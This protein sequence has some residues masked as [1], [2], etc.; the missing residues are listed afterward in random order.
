MY[1]SSSLLPTDNTMPQLST[2]WDASVMLDIFNQHLIDKSTLN[3]CEIVSAT[4]QRIRYRA[5]QRS[6]NLYELKLRHRHSRRTQKRWVTST[7]YKNQRAKKKFKQLANQT[8]GFK[9][10]AI[11][12][13]MPI[14]YLDQYQTFLQSFPFD[15]YLPQLNEF[16]NDLP[17]NVLKLLNKKLEQ[18][19]LR[20]INYNLEPSRYRPSY[21]ST[22]EC[23]LTVKSDQDKAFQLSYYLKLFR[24]G[25]FEPYFQQLME[26]DRAINRNK[27]GDFKIV[28]PD[29]H[30]KS[31]DLIILK[32]A[33]GE[34]L[35]QLLGKPGLQKGQI[36]SICEALY[37]LH[38]SRLNLD[39]YKFESQHLERSTKAIRF[40][41]WACPQT[42]SMLNQIHEFLLVYKSPIKAPT[43]CDIKADHV[44][45]DNSE[46]VTFIDVDSIA[47]SDPVYDL[48][49]LLV[50]LNTLP[51]L[52]GYSRSVINSV[53]QEILE[54]YFKLAPT[55]WQA[56]LNPNLARASLKVC[57]FFIQ[58]QVQNW[59]DIVPQILNETLANLNND[60]DV[61][62]GESL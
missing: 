11:S 23:K 20:L 54:R 14:V 1:S 44:F 39:R 18:Q 10:S 2:L 51:M 30:I 48:A 53:N 17:A 29:G 56:N 50:R 49:M 13:L 31:H 26:L 12:D 21:A 45:F 42:I 38:T 27:Q 22:F 33:P 35:E 9:H 46:K 55:H 60:S 19:G 37:S 58:H 5:R 16:K 36:Q 47:V 24:S 3:D 43:H 8:N 15:R 6:I 41:S 7:T 62:P 32:S 34:S 25:C 59:F 4:L 61:I 28:E 57:L 40:I 52:N